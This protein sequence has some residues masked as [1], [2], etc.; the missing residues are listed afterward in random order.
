MTL[1][2]FLRLNIRSE[3]GGKISI[4]EFGKICKRK[5]VIDPAEIVSV[6]IFG[7]TYELG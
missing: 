4:P 7:Q 6:T 3:K 2:S 1:T 5:Q